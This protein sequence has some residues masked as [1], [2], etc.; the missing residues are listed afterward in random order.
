MKLK[1]IL[2][3]GS[4]VNVDALM[5]RS[6]GGKIRGGTYSVP[7]GLRPTTLDYAGSSP[8][9]RGSPVEKIYFPRM[10]DNYNF[11]FHF[12]SDKDRVIAAAE[13]LGLIQDEA[14]EWYYPVYT[15]SDATRHEITRAK[16]LFGE[17]T[18]RVKVP[19]QP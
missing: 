2:K 19:P 11:E 18:V 9:K 13:N 15:M 4:P 14:G 12:K 6:H 1:D 10:F 5:S 17:R 16:W 7:W 3:E 8:E